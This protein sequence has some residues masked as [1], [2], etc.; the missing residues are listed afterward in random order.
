MTQEAKFR[1]VIIN[2]KGEVVD[3]FRNRCNANKESK[4]LHNLDGELY[5]IRK[6]L[7]I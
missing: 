3:V 2:E 7:R 4:R 1:F 5:D 6:E